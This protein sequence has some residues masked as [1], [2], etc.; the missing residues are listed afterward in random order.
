MLII[1][2]LIRCIKLQANARLY[3][4]NLRLDLICLRQEKGV[5]GSFRPMGGPGRP[6]GISPPR[7]SP[8]LLSSNKRTP[9]RPVDTI[10]DEMGKK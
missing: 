4:A 7:F 10:D 2:A 5:H 6:M 9:A 8:N 3:R 1:Y